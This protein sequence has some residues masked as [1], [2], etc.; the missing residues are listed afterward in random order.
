MERTH[1]TVAT[2]EIYAGRIFEVRVDTVE[3]A[4]ARREIDVVE[5][6]G[7]VAVLA[8]PAPDSLLLVRQYR[9]PAGRELWEIPAGM[10]EPGEEPAVAARRELLEETGYRAARIAPMFGL[11]PTPGFCTELLH[12]FVAEGLEAGNAAPDED[13]RIDLQAFGLPQALA[14]LGDGTICDLKTAAALLW[15]ARKRHQ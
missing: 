1:K 7:S 12:L 5:H 8:L 14:M 4:G 6:R 2:R 3:F 10:I 15:L 9:H 13:E 11:Y